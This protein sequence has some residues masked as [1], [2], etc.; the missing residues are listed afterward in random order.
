MGNDGKFSCYI[1]GDGALLTACGELIIDSGHD[2]YGVI[3]SNPSIREWAEDKGLTCTDH[4]S[5]YVD[6]LKQN[7]FD[8]LF[9]IVYLSLIP[10]KVLALP[11][12]MAINFHD[13]LLPEYA[14]I[15]ATSWAIMNQEKQHGITWHEMVS[16]VDKGNILKQMIIPVEEGETA[17]SLNVK[18][19]KAGLESFR[20]LVEELAGDSYSLT[21][22]DLS[23]RTYY[24]KYQHPPAGGVISWDSSAEEMDA[25]V[26]A[27][28]FGK[29]Q[30]Q[31]GIAKLAVNNEYIIVDQIFVTKNK[32][33]AKPGTIVA[34]A[35]LNFTVATVNND[36]EIRSIR[37]IHGVQL[38]ISDCIE[39]YHLKAGGLLPGFARKTST[40]ITALHKQISRFEDYWI[41]KMSK[42][43]AAIWPGAIQSVEGIDSIHNSFVDFTIAEE[44]ITYAEQDYGNRLASC[45]AAISTFLSKECKTNNVQFF[46]GYQ[47]LREDF[48]GV[49][50]L[51][52][53][54]VPVELELNDTLTFRDTCDIARAEIQSVKEHKTFLHDLIARTPQLKS[55][56]PVHE[57]KL[58]SFTVEYVK[59]LT[60]YSQL[61]CNRYGISLIVPEMGN[62][63]RIA[64]DEA[65]LATAKA[66]NGTNRLAACMARAAATPD[67]PIS[68]LT[69]LTDAEFHKAIYER[70]HTVAE[71]PRDKCMHELFKER[72]KQSPEKIAV[73]CRDESLT[74]MELEE[75]AS[76]LASFLNRAGVGRGDLV[77]I[78]IERS[79]DML[80]GL[81]GVLKAGGTYVPIDPLYP[82][83][84]ILHMIEDADIK[85][86]L[87]QNEFKHKLPGSNA[88]IICL[89]TDW[90]DICINS[91]KS[92]SRKYYSYSSKTVRPEDSAYVI[93]TSGSTGKPKGVEVTQRGLTNFL[94]AM[95]KC[96][97]FTKEDRVLALTT[98]C[99]DIAGLELYL[100]L[101]TG[102]QV[103]ILP[104]ETAR[105]GFALKERI[106]KEWATVVQA[107]PATWE[108]LLEA[109]WDKRTSIKILC[110]GEALSR[111]LAQ[112]LLDRSKEV[113]NM[114][115]PTETTIWSSVSKINLGEEI[116]IGY[117][118]GNTQFY[119]VDEHLNPVPD[120]VEGELCIGGDG[121]AKGYLNRPELT[122][123][124]FILNPFAAD[125]QLKMYRTGDCA[126][127]LPDGRVVCLGRMDNQVK[128]RGFRIELGEI[129]TVLQK[130]LHVKHAV[131]VMKADS[132]GYKSLTAFMVPDKFQ[133]LIA[134]SKLREAM[135]EF[136]PDYMIPASY[137]YL[138]MLPLT[139]N[140]KVDRKVL[141][142]APD[143]QLIEKYGYKEMNHH[144]HI[145]ANDSIKTLEWKEEESK[146]AG[147]FAEDLTKI[148]AGVVKISAEEIHAEIPMGEYGFDS[149]RFTVLSKR[150]K[151][152]YNISVTPAQ[153]YTYET[154]NKLIDYMSKT[155]QEEL[156]KH[157]GKETKGIQD[158]LSKSKVEAADS[159]HEAAFDLF[160][161]DLTQLVAGVVKISAEE[162]HA[163]IP[164]GEYGFDSIRF[165]V[166]SKRIKDAYHISV[167][168][169]QFYT[170]TT[171]KKVIEFLWHAYRDELQK[172]YGDVSVEVKTISG[173]SELKNKE[174]NSVVNF[175]KTNMEFDSDQRKWKKE[176]VAIIGIGGIFP[177]APDLD[178]FWDHIV[179]KRDLITPIPWERWDS[180][181]YYAKIAEEK[182]I[183][184]AKWGGFLE[185][186][187]KFD[188]AFFNISPREAEQMDPQQRIF[189]ETVWKAI[190][191]AGYKASEFS[192][193]KTGVYVGAVSSDYWDMMLCSGLEADSY[194]IS[195]NINCVIANRVSYLLNLQGASA[196]I[197]T[198]CSSSL[199]AIHRAV[200]AIQHGDCDMAIAGGVNVILNPFMHTALGINGMLSADGRCKTFD[201]QA[202]GYVRGEGAGVLILKP[203]SKAIEDG[204]NIHAVIKGS[205]ENHG[206]RTNS[207]TAPNPNAQAGLLISAYSEAEIDP[208]TV[209]YIEAHG[210]GTSLGDPIEINGIKMAFEELGKKWGR[211]GP[212]KYCGIGS[213]KSNIG[214]LEA[215]AGVAGL[216][217]IV[218]AMQKGALPGMI[219]FKEQNPYINLE[220]TQFYI[221]AETQKWQRIR[222]SAGQTVPRRAGVSSFGFGGSNAHVVLEEYCGT[223]TNAE[224][225]NNISNVFLLSAKSEDRLRAY[226]IDMLA[227]LEEVAAREEK[228]EWIGT[229][230]TDIMYTLQ[231]GREAMNKRLAI[232]ASNIKELTEKL[233]QY[234]ADE[235]EITQVYT[236]AGGLETKNISALLEGSNG[237]EFLAAI[238]RQKEY[239]KLAHLWV[240]GAAVD[241]SLLYS[242]SKPVRISLPT[243]PFAKERHW[244]PINKNVLVSKYE[245]QPV[246]L[247]PLLHQNTS[248]FFEQRF[249][250]VFSGNEFFLKDH[251][252]KGQRVLPGVAYLEIAHAAVILASGINEK[253]NSIKIKNVTWIRP[254]IMGDKEL[255]AQI[256][257]LPEENGDINYEIYSQSALDGTAATVHSQGRAVLSPIT[258]PPPLDLQ[259]LQR[260]CSHGTISFGQCYE[261]YRTMGIDYGPGHQGIREIYVGEYQ[262]LAKISM[263]SCV[264]DMQ[265][266]FI[267]H[268]SIMDSALQASI[269]L[270]MSY[271]E[272][273]PSKPIVPFA[274]QEIEVFQKCTS[275][276]WAH[277]CYSNGSKPGDKIQKLDIDICDELGG[278]YVRL[279]GF[280][281][282][283]M[284]KDNI[285]KESAAVLET[286]MF[287]SSWIVKD[288]NAEAA[289][290]DDTQQIVI[291]CE[292]DEMVKEKIKEKMNSNRYLI[293]QSNQEQLEERFQSYVFQVFDE[294]QNVL[295]SK[296]RHNVLIQIVV[297]IQEE[298]Q[299]FSALFALIKTAELENPKVWGQLIEVELGESWER[300]SEKLAENSRCP[301]DRRIQ[302]LNGKRRVA[303][304]REIERSHEVLTTPWKEQG[305]YL[306]TGG[307]GG[308]GLIFAQEIAQQVKNPV[309]ILTGRSALNEEKRKKLKRLVE[310]GAKIEYRQAD[311]T[312]KKA[313]IR[314]IQTIQEQFG[315][316]HGII[317]AAG[318]I[319][320]NFIIKKT[321]EEMQEVLAPKVSGLVYLDHATRNMKL[322]FFILFSSISGSL[323]NV[324]QADYA[325]AN[326]FMNAY[327]R[328]RN[329]LA[330]AKQRQGQTLAINWPLWQAGGMNVNEA[331][332][333][334]MRNMGMGAMPTASG[335]RLFYLGMNTDKDQVLVMTGEPERIQEKLLL[336]AYFSQPDK[337]TAASTFTEAAYASNLLDRIQSLLIQ[338]TSKLLKVRMEEIDSNTELNEYGFDS[339]TFTEFAN[340]LNQEY[341]LELTPVIFFEYP[342]LNRFA[343]YLLESYL[344]EFSSQLAVQKDTDLNGFKEPEFMASSPKVIDNGSLLE[345]IQMILI[346]VVSRLLKVRAND[347]DRNTELNEYGFDSIMYTEFANLLNQEYKFELTP[348]IFFEYSTIQSFAEYLTKEYRTLLVSQF[349]AAVN[350]EQTAIYVPAEGL[351]TKSYS[352]F[353]KTMP[354]TLSKVDEKDQE[355]I[356]I[357]G[358]SGIFP[359]A[360][361]MNELWKNLLEDKD[362]ITE[363]PKSRWDWREYYGDPG[364]DINK[365][366]IK[367]GGFI[368]GIE[369]FDPLFFGI[370]PR[371]AE[372]MDPQQRLLMT[373]AWKAIEDAGYSA[374]SLSGTQTGIFVGTANCSGYSGLVSLSNTV[375]EGYSATGT[376]PSVG[377][378]RMSYFLN[379]HGPSEPIET[380]CSSS[381][382]AI[383]RAVAAIENGACEMAIVGGINTMVT[384]E[385]HISFNKA[386]MLS[387]DGRCKTFSDQA[388]GYVRGEGVGMLFLKKLKDAETD[389]DHIYG[390]VKGTAEN[391]GGHA[392]SLTAPNPK[393]QA[394]LLETAYTKAGIDPRTVTYI[395]AHG[396]GTEL[397]DPIEING[398]KA[399]FKEL[400]Q[401]TGDDAV[402]SR[403]CGLG[404]V[405]TNIGHLE[406]AAGVAGVIKVLLQLKHKTLVKSLHCDTINPYIQL[407]GS[408]FYIVQ[409][410]TEWK[411]L[412]DAAGKEIPR[413]GGVSSFGF[414]GVNAHVVIEEYIPRKQEPI[415]ISDQNP[416]LIVLSAKNEERLKE[417]VQQLLNAIEGQRFF[418]SHLADMAYTLQVGR[419]AMEE[420]LAII[421]GSIKELEERLKCFIEGQQ[422]IRDL[423]IGEVKRNKETVAIFTA[424]EDLERIIDVWVAKRKYK[425]LLN[426]WV[427]GLSFDWNKLYDNAKPQRISL[428]TYPFAKERYWIPSSESKDVSKSVAPM[429]VIHPLLH[430]NI[431]DFSEQRFSSTFTG[432][433][434]FLTDHVVK[435]QRVLPGV[436]YLEMARVAVAQAAGVLNEDERKIR[437]KNVV[438]TQ[439]I[440]VK[441]RPVRVN[442]GLFPEDDGEI[443]YEIYSHSETGS[444]ELVVHSQGIALLSVIEGVETLDIRNLQAECSQRILSSNQCYEAFRERGLD[445]GPGYQGIERVYVGYDQVLVKIFLPSSVSSTQDQFFLHPSLLDSALQASIGFVLDNDDFKLALP[446]ALQEVDILGECKSNMW[447]LIR[448]SEGSKAGDKVQKLDI[449]L[450][451]ET[452]LICLRMKGFSA[453]ILEGK[454]E[455]IRQKLIPIATS[456]TISDSTNIYL[457]N[458]MKVALMQIVSKVLRVK[459]E[460]IDANTELEEY[461]F[462]QIMLGEFANNINQ[463]YKLE[464]TN[465]IFLEYPTIHSLAEYLVVKHQE[466]FAEY[467][468]I[469]ISNEPSKI[470]EKSLVIKIGEDLLR[471]KATIYFKQLLSSVIKLP[472]QRIEADAPMERYGINS[473]MVMQLTNQLEKKFGSLSKTLFFEY[474][475]IQ[476]LTGYFLES[477]RSKLIELLGIEEKATATTEMSNDNIDMTV[478]IKSNIDTH[479]RPRFAALR[480][481]CKEEKK[482][483]GLDVAIIGVSGRYPGA[484]TI[485]E[486]WRNL[487]EGKDCITEIP[488]D[489]WDHSLYY[490]EDKN[491]PG[492]TY[493]KWGGFLDGVDQ[494]DPLFFNITP[495]EAELMDPQER[496]FLQCVFE[497]IEDAGYTREVL[498]HYKGF[499]LEGNI[500]VYVGVM[501]EEYQLYGVQETIQG[502]PIALAGNPSS[503]ANRVSYFCNFHGPSMAIDT[504]CSSS[505]TAIHLACQSLERG[506]CE[507]AIAGG[508]NVS[509]H[510]NKYLMLG[511]GRFVSSKGRCE[512]FGE[513]GDGYVP[514]EGVGAVLLKPLASAIED[515]DHIYGV[516]KGTA[517]NH[518][519]KT[520]GYTVP[521]LN[522]QSGVIGQAFKESGI[523]PRT[524]SYVEAHG[525]GTSLGDPI[526][527]AGLN[528]AFQQFTDDKQFCAIGSAK[529]NIGHC[530]SAAGIA[531]VT[532]I[533]LQLRYHQLVPSLHS[534]VLNPSIDFSNTPFIVQQE[535]AE[536]KRPFVNGHEYPRR[537]GISSFGAGGSNAHILIEEYILKDEKQI[538]ITINNQKPA[539]IVLSARTSEQ[540][541]EQ[542]QRLLVAIQEEKLSDLNLADMAY[543]LQVGREAMKERLAVVV[544]SIT[545]LEEKL[546]GFIEG[547]DDD[548]E[549]LCRGQV[550]RNKKTLD[551]FAADEDM[552]K[553]I[554]AWIEKGKFTK[555]L[556]L[557]VKGL[558][559]DWNKLYSNS[560]PRRISL[561][562]YPFAK[563]RYWIPG[564]ENQIKSNSLFVQNKNQFSDVFYDK[565]MDEIIS[566]GISVDVAIQKMKNTSQIK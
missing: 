69:T 277:V 471:E 2:I 461:G 220:G 256:R 303:V 401:A 143:F 489:R 501:Y 336:T 409:E 536:W 426:L 30:N 346:Q 203:L 451:D 355:A 200:T 226:A 54:H 231:M 59:D 327:A 228:G 424:D 400:Y 249:S 524:I 506:G 485:Q 180:N 233:R 201:S 305:I 225:N 152:A 34:I 25:A 151:D 384:P 88:R 423:Y 316:L 281:A 285:Q 405:K 75:K 381:L 41:K 441:E 348:A 161:R 353:I 294:I 8:Y 224:I 554:E 176:P 29:Y 469:Q 192:G 18:C 112:K 555:V 33:D 415:T 96:P 87:T 458:K 47:E 549:G 377:P 160:S 240:G 538:L 416:A 534:K 271:S 81:L 339:I 367:W 206:G 449:D 199:V 323:G 53:V 391:H 432:Q 517:I 269:G 490:D 344:A 61:A 122:S 116:T 429:T 70:N 393:A 148:I 31:L 113:W 243:Y 179:N 20:D 229:L 169:A 107:T 253:Q 232:V 101:I 386:G 48:Q 49:D 308:L 273:E 513:G 274:L 9:S 525:T 144:I 356:A 322:D 26:R 399:A 64:F 126:K 214:H 372:L 408:P 73:L 468:Q 38:P 91:G 313:V 188:A 198:A 242:H 209:T 97:G 202:N 548:I 531:G 5:D 302:Y 15:H 320:D 382:I 435:G 387:E 550:K 36:I 310:L 419:E 486:F 362:C 52:A 465:T 504:M 251:V 482:S 297:S 510:P 60:D 496:L 217:K 442:I 347:I 222:D 221:A 505:L 530:E 539:I 230:F 110:G 208:S 512:S 66:V 304:W 265:E 488:L 532:K 166:L 35:D 456:E 434:F 560:K 470:K 440:T 527:V 478:S 425:K 325:V 445:Y 487:R 352:R 436:A 337:I 300:F 509:I 276:M 43:D 452:G 279:K 159:A 68:K 295:R 218:L 498:R 431:S 23:R 21:F 263:P 182:K 511:Q 275:A 371:E 526:E 520:N 19:Y 374:Q 216:L 6:F 475:N 328:Y 236:G 343:E 238:I 491:K 163:E 433:E 187:D 508:V 260:Q 311:I 299:L 293:L 309:I 153:F 324:G 120:G 194:T 278:I 165:T 157:Y 450:C 479:R 213:V 519:G 227:F 14:G 51:F 146:A 459:I 196:T 119:I 331:I 121:L 92:S 155:Y 406:L 28:Q 85:M 380:A 565:L 95:A 132:T 280:S 99:F 111:Q 443:A 314:L 340:Q 168:P 494:F 175:N 210:T 150:I 529:S 178:T 105:D 359:M 389:G 350:V 67:A 57:K 392:N 321:K 417:Q 286:L 156:D 22:Q 446:F 147:H 65:L 39:K 370:S 223:K 239:K 205:S 518:G 363:I 13:A 428:P 181:H 136:L 472:A 7:P 368:D 197:D 342:T 177:Q 338:M 186:V 45:L 287:H 170:Y 44:F 141:S 270:I 326:D 411:A 385:N 193:T 497:T 559:F 365:T 514:G 103:E 118:I 258:E 503:I 546:K 330:A 477:Y 174:M 332:E 139:L 439:P 37:S 167:T 94:C 379:I 357:I 522:A 124:K 93:F 82:G 438:W 473:I 40:R 318:V 207:L 463:E 403:H 191:N 128:L 354:L 219:H 360:K 364:K 32:S 500:G 123:E 315:D 80:V 58:L 284:E 292:P 396:T 114:Y 533:L 283:V 291:F 495:R 244:L 12:R 104:T 341:K 492:K 108:M 62:T 255:Q 89:D 78:F 541:K 312:D 515:G 264:R 335:L 117:P 190:E 523:N 404:S 11:Q 437:L 558:I 476:E 16:A 254:M 460:N 164:M 137:V 540:L 390:I 204:D 547:Q 131:V 307:A 455:K 135:R 412:Q 127:Y 329:A 557:W 234:C 564:I 84:R 481:E 421:V 454:I 71:Y 345:N 4:D 109:G 464:L 56:S 237:K 63:W 410:Q 457:P 235:K 383:H 248:D 502:R 333:K 272:I 74:Y 556:D 172:S 414:G 361:D 493:S 245:V 453:R 173:R 521:N 149:I 247:H 246:R 551:V 484:R 211:I 102:G 562:T 563:E 10:R 46:L 552:T 79:L 366:N 262:V 516:I 289:F 474:Q 351:H 467:F 319:R 215:G 140:L 422:N 395:E 444:A 130:Q 306:I 427:K 373:Y 566:D 24:G 420:R 138:E 50:T 418:D 134:G 296:P 90:E 544:E 349:A 499:G 430:Q 250:S 86:V 483:E 394:K 241:W 462:D 252:V 561:P 553:T 195:G 77:G 398:L 466:L 83:E 55:N 133:D 17:H 402:T 154:V 3:S 183:P 259:A 480:T 543:T 171:V 388:N 184:F 535:L 106:E 290:P 378:N 100:P 266:E 447:A 261:A 542:V 98:I 42:M 407:A 334:M 125:L 145:P 288:A 397:G 282:R 212:E 267:M 298:Q 537:A 76:R 376:L 189:L 115:G 317:H 375:I 257:L 72:V 142:A 301:M 268:P 369:E 129:E 528:K 358:V 162:I 185:D 413:R 1:I 545:E 507:L 448:Y 27:L 158:S